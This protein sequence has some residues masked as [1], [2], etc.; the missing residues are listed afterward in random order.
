MKR[1]IR[2]S[3]L[4]LVLVSTASAQTTVNKP[5][6]VEQPMSTK[7]NGIV[8]SVEGT[9]TVNGEVFKMTHAYARRVENHQDKSKQDV[10]IAFTDRAVARQVFEGS[11]MLQFA[12]GSKAKDAELRGF[13]VTISERDEELEC[14]SRCSRLRT[15]ELKAA[16]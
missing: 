9:L 4:T 2:S 14:T 15:R 12:L 3:A 11:R 8:N 13:E 7:E 6:A 16:L 10:L 1:S 5:T